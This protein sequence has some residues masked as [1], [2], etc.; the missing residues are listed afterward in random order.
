[1]TRLSVRAHVRVVATRAHTRTRLSTCLCIKSAT[2]RLDRATRCSHTSDARRHCCKR[3]R[4]K[5]IIVHRF[6]SHQLLLPLPLLH[7]TMQA[8]SM[9]CLMFVHR[10]DVDSTWIHS[11]TVKPELGLLLVAIM[12]RN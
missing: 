2:C 9:Q 1:M 10:R 8:H 3:N 12:R 7:Q 4:W 5:H 11:L 6:I